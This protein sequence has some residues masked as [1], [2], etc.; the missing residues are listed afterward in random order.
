MRRPFFGQFDSGAVQPTPIVA[1]FDTEVSDYALPDP[2]NLIELTQEQ[3]D[4]RFDTPYVQDGMLIAPP[5]YSPT[6]IEQSYAL[7]NAGVILTSTGT[8]AVN[9]TYNA[10][11]EAVS[12]LQSEMLSILTHGFFADGTVSVEWVDTSGVGHVFPNTTVFRAFAVA[13]GAFVA[14]LIKVQLGLS[15]V[16]PDP[17][18]TIA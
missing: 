9:G 16:L 5:L 11:P 7:L 1:W 4:V 12:Y 15:T 2:S 17:N 8:P 18:I 13:V 10:H 14:N 6:L 3:W